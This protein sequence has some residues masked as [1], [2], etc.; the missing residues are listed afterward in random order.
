[1]AR[2]SYTSKAV[3]DATKAVPILNAHKMRRLRRTDGADLSVSEVHLVDV[4]GSN[5]AREA[6]ALIS[7]PGNSCPANSRDPSP[8]PQESK[9]PRRKLARTDSPQSMDFSSVA[10]RS[11]CKDLR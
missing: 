4:G 11:C 7:K 2:S 1:M 5:E 6:Q 10:T 8:P 9:R 3:A